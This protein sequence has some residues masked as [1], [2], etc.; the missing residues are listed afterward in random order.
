[1][2]KTNVGATDR[3]VRIAVGLALL[4]LYFVMPGFGYRWVFIL[5]GVIALGT[6]LLK[7][8]PL[9]TVLGVSTD[10]QNKS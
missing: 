4:A 2:F 10:Q 3:I 5:L 6:G 1:M 8:C 9:Y 7:T